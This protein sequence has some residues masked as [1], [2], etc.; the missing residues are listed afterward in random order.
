VPSRQAT[1]EARNPGHAL[2]DGDNSPVHSGHVLARSGKCR[3]LPG[4]NRSIGRDREQVPGSLHAAQFVPAAILEAQARADHDI[5]NGARNQ[6]L[7]GIRH[8]RDPA[9]YMNRDPAQRLADPLTL[10]GVNT[11]PG[12]E[13]KGLSTSRTRRTTSASTSHKEVRM[14]QVLTISTTWGSNDPTRATIPFHLARGAKQAG[15]QVRVVLACDSTELIRAG[16]AETVRGK[17]VPPLKEVL[18]FARDS[19]ITIHV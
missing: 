14:E 15:T 17:G 2:G 10:A 8:R 13:A 1:E 3:G 11:G 6:N 9:R 12:L 18:H 19:G 4:G 5:P 16:M 7:V